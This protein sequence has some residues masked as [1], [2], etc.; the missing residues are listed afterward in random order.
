MV[1]PQIGVLQLRP[2]VVELLLEWGTVG[3][4]ADGEVLV[5]VV[6]LGHCVGKGYIVPPI[7]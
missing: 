1:S 5:G 2:S 4:N 7:K 3:D 6:I